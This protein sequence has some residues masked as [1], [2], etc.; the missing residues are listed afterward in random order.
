MACQWAKDSLNNSHQILNSG[1][2]YSPRSVI[3]NWRDRRDG[4][5]PSSSTI[6]LQTGFELSS[7]SPFLM[8]ITVTLSVSHIYIYIYIYTISFKSANR[9][10]RNNPNRVLNARLIN[11]YREKYMKK[12]TCKAWNISNIKKNQ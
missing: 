9:H 5:I 6:Q 2:F 7:M 11:I 12:F 1:F 3:N 8:M 4:F 10:K